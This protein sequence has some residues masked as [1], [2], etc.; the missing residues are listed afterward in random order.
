MS[1]EQASANAAEQEL[2]NTEAE[3]RTIEASLR[4]T[5]ET[6]FKENDYLV[7]LK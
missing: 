2:R 5:K 6:Q 1:G 7:K 4:Q 3:F